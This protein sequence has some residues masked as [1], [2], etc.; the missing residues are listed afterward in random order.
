MNS[1]YFGDCLDV[2][3]ELNKQHP[4]GSVRLPGLGEMLTF[5]SSTKRLEGEKEVEGLFDE[6]LS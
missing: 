3:K 1:L 5:K 2:L 6:K 4:V